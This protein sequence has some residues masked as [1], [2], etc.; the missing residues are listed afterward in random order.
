VLLDQLQEFL[1]VER[2]HD[3]RGA[4]S[5]IAI[6]LKRKGAAWYSGAGDR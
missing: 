3:H 4:P 1:G 5:V 6:M 2:F